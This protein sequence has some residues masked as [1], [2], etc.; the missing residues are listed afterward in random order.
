MYEDIIK[1][2][3]QEI[4]WWCGIDSSGSGKGHA[5]RSCKHCDEL[6]I[7]KIPGLF[8]KLIKFWLLKKDCT[9]WN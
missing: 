3:I 9:P 5:A 2:N 6:G 1:M 7:C 8:L 4:G